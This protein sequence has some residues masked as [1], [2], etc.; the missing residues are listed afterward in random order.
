MGARRSSMHPRA[1]VSSSGSG[2][3]RT[4]AL[5]SKSDSRMNIFKAAAV[6][7]LEEATHAIPVIDFG[8]AF[9]ANDRALDDV[10]TAVRDACERVG[11]FYMAG[12]GVPQAT[13]DAA[14]EAAREFH[15]LPV[16]EKMRLRINENNIGYLPVNQSM[17]RAST[18]H[19]NTRPNF[20]ESFFISHDRSAD[21]PDVIAGLP[22]RGRNLWPD[23]HER[24]R[25]AMLQY[26][27][28]LESVSERMLPVLA[29]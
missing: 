14:F 26:F 4:A 27:R 12:H 21:H 10:A 9:R 18:V 15:A 1:I 8:P 25:F 17:Q 5:H 28:T 29:R 3:A 23:G 16:E 6:R 7:S 22:L 2:C 20:N 13:I 24:M 19:K 11:F